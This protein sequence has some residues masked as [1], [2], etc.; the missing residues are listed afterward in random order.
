MT[1]LLLCLVGCLSEAPQIEAQATSTQKLHTRIQQMDV[2][3]LHQQIQ[4]GNPVIIDVRTPKEFSSGHIPGAI[5][6]PLSEL[7][8]RTQELTAYQNT[9]V[10]LVCAAGGRSQNAAEW[11]VSQGFTQPINIREGTMGYA[12]V[13][14]EL[15]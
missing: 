6:I 1:T 14:F 10:Y 8:N 2:V 12:K 15:E 7:P 13:G 4:T 11:L 3:K 9:P 5:S